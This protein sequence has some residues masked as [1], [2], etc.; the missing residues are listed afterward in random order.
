V[1]LSLPTIESSYAIHA[2]RAFVGFDHPDSA[3][4]RIALEVLDGTE[5]FLWVS[6]ISA[7]E[8]AANVTKKYIRGAGLAYGANMGLSLESGLVSFSLYRVREHIGVALG[9]A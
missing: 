6:E 1:V 4:L 5:S 2:A 7:F 9:C 3:A 8:R